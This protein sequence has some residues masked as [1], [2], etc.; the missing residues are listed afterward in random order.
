MDTTIQA[1]VAPNRAAGLKC[2]TPPTLTIDSNGCISHANNSAENL[3]DYPSGEM[4]GLHISSVVPALE[5]I[6]VPDQRSLGLV[7]Y[8]SRCGVSFTAHDSR[9]QCF[10]CKLSIIALHD[11]RYGSYR[12]IVT[13]PES[14]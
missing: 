10:P 6:E 12:V 7:R 1:S 11:S 3:F 9:R 13:K 5:E 4:V 8:L 14:H 2:K